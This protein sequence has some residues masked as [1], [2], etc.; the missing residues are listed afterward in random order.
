MTIE[1]TASN[2]NAVEISTDTIEAL[3]MSLR[4]DVVTQGSPGYDEARTIWNAMH[5]RQ[6]G[7]VIRALGASDI[8]TAVNFA[9]DN[10]LLISIR[11]GG[12]QIAGHAVRD[13]VLMLDLSNMKSVYVDP[14]SRRARVEP[15]ATLGDVDKE[16]QVHGLAVPVGINS[17]TGIA[18]LTL[19][20]GF[21]W[22]TRKYGMTI[23][24]LISAD[25]VLADGSMI[26]ASADENSD[27]FWAIRGGGGNFGVISS[28]EFM[29]HPVGPE[30]TAG[31]IVHPLEA[32]AD[33]L[34]HYERIAN[35]A[36]DE[37]TVW[38]VMRKA[39]PLP[40]LPPE[41][42]GRDVLIFAACLCEETEEGRKSLTELQALGEPIVDVMGPNPFVGWEA[43]FDP[44]LTP[45]ARNYWKSHDLISLPVNATDLIIEAVRNTPSPDCEI[46]LAHL[47]GAMSQVEAGTTAYP[48]RNSHF[49]M[50][51]HTR[52][53]SPDDDD[54]CRTWARTLFDDVSPF[55][56]GTA[57]VNFVPDDEPERMADV[58][59]TNYEKLIQAKNTYDPKN[60]FR[61]NHNIAPQ[62]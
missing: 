46:F 54:I 36:P 49:I 44:L 6:P 27:L 20:G 11:S 23:D 14:N 4:G 43:A 51:V 26:R 24:N 21:G 58:Y 34:P 42:H 2:G 47:G 17:T 3:N 41:W 40:F 1:V 16:T 32:A 7:L 61:I 39:P 52:W 48:Q 25:V 45:G 37:L 5:D 8:Q 38:V 15:G 56:A 33:L 18:G 57:Y 9:R 12:H 13:G 35:T 10:G 53:H 19:G 59:G 28:F 62:V 30:V 55:S 31:L 22:I 60:L 50:N 29:L